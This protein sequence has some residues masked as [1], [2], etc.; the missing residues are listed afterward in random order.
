MTPEFAVVP[1]T[2]DDFASSAAHDLQMPLAALDGFR[3]Q[4]EHA[5]IEGDQGQAQYC[6]QRIGDVT[7]QMKQLTAGLLTL[8][9]VG[10]V[11]LHRQP[12]NLSSLAQQ[13]IDE[14]REQEPLRQVL[15]QIE[16]ELTVQGDP[17]L[18][19]QALHNLLGNAWKFT[20]HQ[21]QASIYV[22]A[23]HSADGQT[24]YVVRDNGVG[25]DMA[26]APRLFKPFE[27]LHSQEEFAGSGIG[28]ATVQRIVSRHGG[29]ISAK[30]KPG[31]GAV[32]RFSLSPPPASVHILVPDGR[33][34]AS[35]RRTQ[36]GKL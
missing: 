4:L 5:L 34:A 6:L 19:R 2:L 31:Q 1:A 15:V 14:L 35:V 27:R 26:Y 17:V 23:E 9:S 21:P 10:H 30:G 32:F 36:A 22:G 16:P 18:L 8:A 33:A 29:D 13:V 11:D 7:R 28:L 3:M 25:F 20:R 24:F 12:V